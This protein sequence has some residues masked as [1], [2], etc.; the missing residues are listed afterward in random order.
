MTGKLIY[1]ADDEQDILDVMQEFLQ[2]AGFDVRTFPT[3]D[4]LFA[5]F[6]QQPC[7]Q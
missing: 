7:W 5:A 4:A 2:N 1:A 6:Q 3:G